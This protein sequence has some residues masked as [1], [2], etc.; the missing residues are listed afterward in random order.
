M[1]CDLFRTKQLRLCWKQIMHHV[2][3]DGNGC[4]ISDYVADSRNY[5]QVR[6]KKRKY[7]IHVVAAMVQANRWP[8]AGEEASHLCHQKRCCNPKHM[9]LEDGAINKS[10]LCCK[11]CASHTGYKCPHEPA[12]PGCVPFSLANN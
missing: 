7:Y 2:K 10:R 9:V 11:L 1:Y 8:R 4:F 3:E 12:C 5:A 6:F